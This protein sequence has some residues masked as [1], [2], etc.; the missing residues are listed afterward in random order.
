[1]LQYE[2]PVAAACYSSWGAVH[3]GERH[4]R[5]GGR[6]KQGRKCGGA[7]RAGPA[8]ACSRRRRKGLDAGGLS[9]RPGASVVVVS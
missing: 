5:H 3:G 2:P 1:M 4:S 8:Y 7:A 9:G 6:G